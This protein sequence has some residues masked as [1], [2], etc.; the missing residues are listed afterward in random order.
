M[1]QSRR[2]RRMERHHQ[3]AKAPG[4]NLVSLMD[5]FTILVFFLLVNTSGPQNLPSIKQVQLPSVVSFNPPA[6]TLVLVVT[7][8]SVLLQ[9]ALVGRW[10]NNPGTG[11][12]ELAG[13]G[14][15]LAQALTAA[16]SQ[17]A[18]KSVAPEQGRAI[19][20]MADERVPYTLI[21]RLLD[22]CQAQ[23]YRQIAFAATLKA[24]T[25]GRP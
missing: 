19:T 20:V 13:A 18:A 21:E 4:L 14:S 16:L 3:L 24:P 25:S 6:E 17:H 7:Q 11:Q 22:L 23:D 12:T 10:V 9:G 1:N 2:A 5:I 15:D 8:D